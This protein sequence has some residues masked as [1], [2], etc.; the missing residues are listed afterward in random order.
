MRSKDIK[1]GQ[2]YMKAKGKRGNYNLAKV[3]VIKAGVVEHIWN[4]IGVYGS[5]DE[6]KLAVEKLKKEFDDS[7]ILGW[8][9]SKVSKTYYSEAGWAVM[10]FTERKFGGDARFCIVRTIRDDGSESD[11]HSIPSKDIRMEWADWEVKQKR[12]A[13]IRQQ[14]HEKRLAADERLR[15]LR[16]RIRSLANMPEL[17]V[18]KHYTGSMITMRFDDLDHFEEFVDRWPV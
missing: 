9:V 11:L 2:I 5:R 6:A 13:E 4:R 8:R 12:D 1:P 18:E 15:D 10:G 17:K 3:K 7:E 14:E 16:D